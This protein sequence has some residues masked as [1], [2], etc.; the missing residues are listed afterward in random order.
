MKEHQR[1]KCAQLAGFEQ[2][3]KTIPTLFNCHFPSFFFCREQNAQKRRSVLFADGVVPGEGTS[4]S[5]D[6]GNEDADIVSKP[7]KLSA[8][9]KGKKSAKHMASP[10]FST[11]P[12][13]M[14]FLEKENSFETKVNLHN[15]KMN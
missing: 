11:A 9:A 14:M 4:A 2:I 5:D 3:K 12:T 6:S 10:P 8:R 15:F 1:G 7:K 13:S